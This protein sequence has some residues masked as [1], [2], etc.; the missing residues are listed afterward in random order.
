MNMKTFGIVSCN[1]HVNFTNYGSAL[2][3]WAL[4]RSVEN[5]G[6]VAKLVDYC[7][8]MMEERDILNP[9]KH[10]WDTDEDSRR[11]LELSMPAIRVNYHKFD[12]FYNRRFIKTAKT[13]FCKN[14]NEIVKD[15]NIDGFV[16]GSDTIFCID[17]WNGFED[18]YFAEYPCM[19]NGYAVSYAAS[20]GDAHFNEETYKLLDQKLKNFKALG[21]REKKMIPYVKEHSNLPVFRTIDPT[22]LLEA[23]DYEEITAPRIEKEKYLLLYARRY[24]K[25]MFDYA[26]TVAAQ[27]GWKVVDISLRAENAGKHRMAYDAGVEEFLSLV[28]YS[29]FVVTNSFHGLIFATQ[30]SRPFVAF[31]RESGD[32]KIAELLSLF[33]LSDRLLVTGEENFEVNVNYEAVHARIAPSRI[34][35]LNFLKMELDGVSNK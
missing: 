32:S 10:M 8:K 6:Y 20:F 9:M 4:C 34:D 26:E 15:E 3:S 2:Q 18:A 7:P 28:K 5:L 1:T 12:T 21:I 19:K 24:N 23:N 29:E 30:F 16:C 35:S 33:G 31:S 11:N 17:E 14:Y 25:R 22:L 27:N 13:Y